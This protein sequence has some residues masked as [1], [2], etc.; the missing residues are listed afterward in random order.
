VKI[1]VIEDNR[2]VAEG[3]CRLLHSRME[4]VECKIVG[5]LAEGKRL[6]PEFQ[7]DV[8][9]IDIVLPDATRQ[10]VLEAINEIYPPVVVV[11]ALLDDDA[12][13]AALCWT[14]GAKGVLSK[15]GLL[16]KIDSI[17]GIIQKA[18]FIDAV[19]GSHL[20]ATAPAQLAE[21]QNGNAAPAS[22]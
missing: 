5:T 12:D 4:F 19:T 2:E 11:S 10:E 7:A 14:Y 13:L 1:L 3:L 22:Q 21:R 18:R 15:R 9:T 6:A 20:R 17:Q 8:T 16:E